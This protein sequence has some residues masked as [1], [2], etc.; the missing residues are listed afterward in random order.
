M[1][2]VRDLKTVD[3]FHEFINEKDG[4]VRIVKLSAPWCG[5]CKV[6]A[7]T[8]RGLDRDKIGDTLFAEINIDTDETEEIGVEC[9]IRG[10]PVLLYYKDGIERVR[11]LGAVPSNDIYENIEKLLC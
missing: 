5:P 9:N 2:T 4:K 6:L 10:V 1:V 3:D 7:E 11:S 8:I